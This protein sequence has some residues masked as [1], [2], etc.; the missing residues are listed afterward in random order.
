MYW[1]TS[2]TVLIFSASSSGISIPNS[3]SIFI[4]SSTMSRESAQGRR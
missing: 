4:T 3:S 2:L 1:I